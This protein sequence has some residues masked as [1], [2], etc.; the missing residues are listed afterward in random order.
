M[1]AVTGK[2]QYRPKDI[3]NFVRLTENRGLGMPEIEL[4]MLWK[5]YDLLVQYG[6][7]KDVLDVGS[8]QSL[9]WEEINQACGKIITADVS[10]ENLIAARD[11]GVT[12]QINCSAEKLPFLN[13]SFDVVSALEMIYYVENQSVFFSE[14]HRVLRPGGKLLITMPNPSRKGFHKSPH[15]T[16]YLDVNESYQNLREVGF[17]AEVFGSF[18]IE[19]SPLNTVIALCFKLCVTLHLVPRSLRGRSKI[20]RFLQGKLSS[21]ESLTD[22]AK[23]LRDTDMELIPLNNP[24]Q[25]F[26]VLYAIGTRDS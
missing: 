13:N 9:G 16:K 19:E 10:F 1:S 7:N 3:K 24:S 18:R 2:I 4:R 23:L 11:S 22:I 15:S 8:G 20:K 21:F 12:R 6:K 25:N 17:S 26:S 5:R 14:C